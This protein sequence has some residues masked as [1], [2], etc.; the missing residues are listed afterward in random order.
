MIKLFKLVVIGFICASGV[1]ASTVNLESQV[2]QKNHHK[3]KA[4]EAPASAP[5]VNATKPAAKPALAHDTTTSVWVQ[6]TQ[7]KPVVPAKPKNLVAKVRDLPIEQ[8]RLEKQ[9]AQTKTD[10]EKKLKQLKEED[11]Q[12]IA[13][14]KA[15]ALTKEESTQY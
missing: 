11:D 9:L 8:Q 13:K 15:D 7:S 5:I 1:E 3:H 12:K 4:A 2:E 10:F 6:P 14:V